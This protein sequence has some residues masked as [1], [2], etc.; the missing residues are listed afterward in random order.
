M[1]RES[2]VVIVVV[3]KIR[4]GIVRHIQ[5]GPAIIIVIAP[6]HSQ[7]VIFAGVV[8][9]RLLRHFLKRPVAAIVVQQVRFARHAPGAALHNDAAK[10]AGAERAGIIHVHMNV[11]RY[12]NIHEA[13]FVVVRPG[14]AGHEA[15]AAHA[16]FVRYILE[17]AIAQVAIERIPAVAGDK[18]VW[19]AVIIEV[20]DGHAHAPA[21]AR[22][23][24]LLGNVF[25]F[26][27]RGLAVQRNHRIA[28]L[29]VAIDRRAVYD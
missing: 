11:A 9:A 24:R 18:D 6:H 1:V 14:G 15:A 19:K 3:E 26:Q 22:Q 27:R 4:P 2:P 25:E 12:E 5:I 10:L 29:I 17:F 20:R 16:G 23:A 7:S 21:F 13:V 8:H 28:A